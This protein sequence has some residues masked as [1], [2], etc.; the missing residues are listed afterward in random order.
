MQQN[1]NLVNPVPV[2]ILAELVMDI[3]PF[4]PFRLFSI[5]HSLLSYYMVA[6][7]LLGPLDQIQQNLLSQDL[8]ALM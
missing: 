3:C 8:I 2:P 4:R 5:W 1:L 7:D 6:L